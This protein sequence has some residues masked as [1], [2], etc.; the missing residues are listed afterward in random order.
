MLRAISFFALL[1]FYDIKGAKNIL[2]LKMTE[3]ILNKSENNHFQR[4]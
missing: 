3:Y 2:G 1:D 4:Q